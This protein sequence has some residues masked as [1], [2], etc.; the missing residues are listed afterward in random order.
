MT[1]PMTS[2]LRVLV[3][4]DSEVDCELI[5]RE[6]SRDGRVV[7]AQRVDN[8]ADLAVALETQEWDVILADYSMPRFCGIEALADLRHR[9]LDVPFIFV[10]GTIGEERAVAAM[11]AGARDYVSKND[12]RRLGPAVERELREAQMRREHQRAQTQFRQALTMAADAMLALDAE[13]RIRIF[14]Q[15]AERVFG[16]AGEEAIG[17]PI[18]QL[19]PIRHATRQ[20]A[21]L[22][23]ANRETVPTAPTEIYGRRKD[24][25]EFRGEATVS[26]LGDDDLAFAVVIRDLSERKQADAELRLVQNIARIS[27]QAA[28]LQ[29]AITVCLGQICTAGRWSFGQAWM[30]NPAGTALLCSRAW[31]SRDHRVETFRAASE[32][33]VFARGDGLPGR[34]WAEQRPQW[35]TACGDP[36]FSRRAA[37]ESSGFRTGAAFPVMLGEEVVAVLEFFSLEH[38]PEDAHTIRLLM[39]L[40]EQLA[41]VMQR[42]AAE[43]QLRYLAHH[44]PLTELPNR[45]LFVDRLRRAIWEAKRHRRVVAVAFLDLDRFKT[46]N[47]SL[48]HRVGDQLLKAVAGRLCAVLREGDTVARLSGDEF[49]LVLADMAD[50][51]DALPVIQKVLDSFTQPF[52]IDDYELF[53]STSIGV[54]LWPDDEEDFESLLRNADI[55]MYRA[56]EAG[57]NAYQ[58]YSSDMTGKARSWL[59]L[60]NELRAA[61]AR[62]EF[63]LYYQP[64]LDLHTGQIEAAEALLRWHHPERGMVAPG[65]FIP[66]SEETGLIIPV[67]DWVLE[68]ACREMGTLRGSAASMRIA[69]NVS[70]RQFQKPGFTD[71]VI[72]ILEKTGFDP[73]RLELEIT[74]GLL[75]QSAGATLSAVEHLGRLGVQFA[76]D[77]FGTGYSSLA[78]LKGLPISRIKIDRSFVGEIP[79]NSN[80]AAIVCAIISMAKSLG[81]EVVA[82]G[83]ETTSQAA[84]LRQHSCDVIQGYL[85][86]PP[87]PL[88]HFVQFLE[89]RRDL[90]VVAP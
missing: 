32:A 62:Q 84:F 26:R 37:A 43:E 85:V 16:Y 57:G 76:I 18:E 6:L 39:T 5:V 1:G 47:D 33:L 42:T 66:F 64:L 77:D 81:I 72:R 27:A 80:D 9:H 35:V 17:M 58:F 70:P 23:D 51:A 56:K 38:R 71:S 83:V 87:Q 54:T 7:T 34:A 10:S 86:K 28:D 89:S 41:G 30:P 14:N 49:A 74:E 2:V 67:G 40:S 4:D 12:L 44:D 60:E 88:G 75:M 8:R 73:C 25:S 55:A 61:L 65:A 79:D 21:S 50:S 24:G 15:G 45:A 11:R 31:H 29:S 46:V 13:H 78:Y 63:E 82:E 52:L 20:R 22:L 48:S 19:M 69:V 68:A 53:A 59:T 90:D 36:G 3:L